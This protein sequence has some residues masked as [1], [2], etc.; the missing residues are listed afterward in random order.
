MERLT[1]SALEHLSSALVIFVH[2]LTGD[3]G[4]APEDQVHNGIFLL[5]VEFLVTS[6]LCSV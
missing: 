1:L 2:D 4:T 5:A 3:C 6:V